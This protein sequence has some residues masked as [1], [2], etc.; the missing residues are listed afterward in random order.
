MAFGRFG[1]AR[2]GSLFA[3]GLFLLF[4]SGDVAQGQQPSASPAVTSVPGLPPAQPISEAAK[5]SVPRSAPSSSAPPTTAPPTSAAPGSSSTSFPT[6]ATP[7]IRETS[8]LLKLAIGD[9]VEVGVYNVPE[10]TT[11]ARVG[12]S[13]DVYLPL[14]D[15][16][17]VAD[18]TVEEAQALI[19]KRLEDGG[20]VRNA[21]VTIFVDESV[22]QGVTILG[23]VA[24]PGIYPA[25]G[26]RKLYDL[27]SAA[28]GFTQAAG[29]R[30]S[31]IRQHS[32]AP[33]ITVNLARNLADDMRDDIEI[34]PGDTITVPRAPIIYV[35]GDVGRPTGLLIDNGSL[36]VLQALALA[37]GTNHTAKMS[38][39]RIIRKG[40]SGMTETRVPLK[41][42]LEAKAPDITLQADD[43]LFVPLSGAR[44]A[45]AQALSAAI[46]AATGIAVIAAH[47]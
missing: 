19:Q 29:R 17:H 36:T 4:V 3:L 39:T 30:V 8:S 28:G 12:T 47:P 14:I 18:L 34:M 43:I 22:S 37:G 41:R 21:H 9:L 25:L 38:G 6:T 5:G 20:F 2:S 33:P 27:I 46:S 45:G 32:S 44:V 1:L 42:M 13:G 35:V 15:Y 11:K 40:S 7:E 24:R 16:I 23:E 26:D 10:L 31:V